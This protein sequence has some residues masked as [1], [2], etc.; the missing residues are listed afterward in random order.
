MQEIPL[1][2]RSSTSFSAYWISERLRVVAGVALA[3]TTITAA[4]WIGEPN[5]LA[6]GGSVLV[7][8]GVPLTFLRLLHRGAAGLDDPSPPATLS[9]GGGPG[10]LLN[11]H[12]LSEYFERLFQNFSVFTGVG[13]LMVGT[14]LAGIATPIWQLM[15]KP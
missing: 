8:A 1:P 6:I 3:S 9:V 11:P 2:Q 4:T 5:F 12:F 14:A 7:L 10:V 15:L 13:Y